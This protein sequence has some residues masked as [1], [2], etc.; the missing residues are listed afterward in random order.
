M[1]GM[2]ARRNKMRGDPEKFLRPGDEAIYK[3]GSKKKGT[4]SKKGKK[5]KTG[6]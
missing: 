1:P 6:Y 5:S 3:M 2:T 4:K